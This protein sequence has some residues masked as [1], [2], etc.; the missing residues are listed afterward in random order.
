MPAYLAVGLVLFEVVL[1]V[2][3]YNQN[4]QLNHALKDNQQKIETVRSENADVKNQLYLV[5]DMENS[6][7]LAAKFG[8]VKERK[9][10]Y[11]AIR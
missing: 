8:L 5:M 1:S 11:L 2:L 9:P 4:V 6:D 7:Q 10:D 3:F